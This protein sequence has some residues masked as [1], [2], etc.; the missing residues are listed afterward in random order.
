MTEATA[1]GGMHIAS[2]PVVLAPRQL[3]GLLLGLG[4]AT[5]MQFYTFDSINLILPDMAGAFGATRDEASWILISYSAAAFVGTPLSSYFARRFGLLPYLI[6]SVVVFL[7]CSIGASL[8]TRL[9]EMVAIRSVEGLAAGGLNFWWRGSVYTFLTGPARSAAMMRISV[10]LYC[11]TIIGL[12]VSGLL[13]DFLTWRFV[14]VLDGVFA[15]AAVLLL[16]AYFPRIAPAPE[17]RTAPLDMPG[18]ILVGISLVLLQVILSRGEIDDWFGSPLIRTLALIALAALGLF[19]LRQ[20]DP[21]NANPLLRLWMLR[22]RSVLASA[23]LGIFTGVILG[24][25]IYALPEYLRGE[26]AVPRSASQTGRI[27]CAYAIAAACIRPF[28]TMATGRF[29]QR[30]LAAFALVSLVV[31][32]AVMARFLTLGTPAEYY[33]LPLVLYAFCLAPLLSAVGSGTAA[34][35]P[36]PHQIDAVTLYMTLRQFGA[37]LGV[38]I[39][40]IVIDWRESLHSSRLFEHLQ[41]GRATPDAWLGG[42]SRSMVARDGWSPADA[43][44]RALKVLQ[45]AAERQVSALAYADAFLVMGAIG[46]I[47]LLFVPLMPPP[48]KKK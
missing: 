37:G 24:G 18:I 47:A 23:F 8:S 15:L 40:N 10:M 12:L 43:T 39:V 26:E 48:A 27:L 35:V 44:A 2:G 29:G 9:D 11:A 45:G 3:N 31:S 14:C 32:M 33:M 1:P 36:G 13:V 25:A 5:G 28:V 38:A 42:L 7:A 17:H 41:L 4:L 22:D 6:G 30:K 16:L 19:I 46:A 20:L 34:R 21:A